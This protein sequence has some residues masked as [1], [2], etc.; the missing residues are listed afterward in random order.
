MQ[1]E[2]LPLVLAVAQRMLRRYVHRRFHLLTP[3][4]YA[5]PLPQVP[6]AAG[7]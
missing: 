2:P 3:R 1:A 7:C 6:Q 4:Y 5:M